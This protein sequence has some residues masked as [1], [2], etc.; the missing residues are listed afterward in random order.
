MAEQEEEY[1][2]H[3]AP[4]SDESTTAAQGDRSRYFFTLMSSLVTFIFLMPNSALNR[5]KSPGRTASISE[6]GHNLREADTV[7]SFE[8]GETR[9]KVS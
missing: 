8:V 7:D 9:K 2:D 5:T 4:E 3:R 6:G 1:D